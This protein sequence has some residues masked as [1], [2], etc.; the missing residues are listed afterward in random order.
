M[1][2]AAWCAPPAGGTT[3][4]ARISGSAV[5]RV[6]AD[7]GRH[8]A[9]ALKM[10]PTWPLILSMVSPSSGDSDHAP[11]IRRRVA[12]RYKD[13]LKRLSWPLSQNP[14]RAGTFCAHGHRWIRPWAVRMKQVSLWLAAPNQAHL[15]LKMPVY[16]AAC[17][18][19]SPNCPHGRAL[20]C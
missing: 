12:E 20:S 15:I 3:P 7:L 2:A 18:L 16:S 4:R 1:L 5:L 17:D 8:K 14:A 13:A 6:P 9:I 19:G 11:G 10:P